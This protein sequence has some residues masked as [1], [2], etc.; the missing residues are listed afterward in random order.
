MLANNETGVIQPIAQ[1]SEI[2]HRH[3]GYLLVDAVQG[4]GRL[5]LPM[6]AQGADFMLLSAHKAGGPKGVGALLLGSPGLAPAPLIRG[7]GQENFHRAGTENAV[8]IAGFGAAVENLP[9]REEW[10]A[11]AQLRDLLTDGLRTISGETGLPEPVVFGG[12]AERLANTLC[13]AVPGM[14][15]ETALISLDLAGIAISSG[16]ACSSGKVRKSHVLQAMSVRDDLCAGALR[17]SLG[18]S[19]TLSE[20]TRFLAAWKDMAGRSARNAA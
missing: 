11:I 1:V 19:S 6:A 20:V 3:G 7:G 15:A 13:F 5:D 4:L 18:S 17:I 10:D 14:K 8:A 2:V 12:D 16:S 9:K